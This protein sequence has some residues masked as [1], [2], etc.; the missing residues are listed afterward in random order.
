[1]I[2]FVGLRQNGGQLLAEGQVGIFCQ[3]GKSAI[4]LRCS[5]LHSAYI[6]IGINSSRGSVHNAEAETTAAIQRVFH[7]AEVGIIA[8]FKAFE[9]LLVALFCLLLQR[10]LIYRNDI[11]GNP[12]V[13][14]HAIDGN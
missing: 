2:V 6:H 8:I 13:I 9:G 3:H 1:M 10:L 12:F 11:Q 7:A 5:F 14:I 4:P